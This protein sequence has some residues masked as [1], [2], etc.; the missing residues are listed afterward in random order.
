MTYSK[1]SSMICMKL[2]SVRRCHLNLGLGMSEICNQ[3]VKRAADTEHRLEILQG[4]CAALLSHC[5]SFTLSRVFSYW[6]LKPPLV[7]LSRTSRSCL[8]NEREL[9][10]TL[11]SPKI[12][13]LARTEQ[14]LHTST[15]T[16]IRTISGQNDTKYCS[17]WKI[18][19]VTLKGSPLKWHS[20]K[21]ELELMLL[22]AALMNRDRQS[23]E[24]QFPNSGTTLCS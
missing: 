10:N 7:F 13:P 11:K 12:T 5:G 1:C 3:E 24:M 8:N 21:T 22:S 14:I 6:W 16:L 2:L 18:I 9:C 23:R 20:C 17:K 15:V 4:I 19:T